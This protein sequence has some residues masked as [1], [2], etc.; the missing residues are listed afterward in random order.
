MM[1]LERSDE[2][3]RLMKGSV[4]PVRGMRRVTPPMMTNACME[5]A[6]TRPTPTNAARS[7]LARA[8]VMNPRIANSRK[9]RM[10]AAAPRSPSS[11]PM[12]EKMKSVETNGMR[13]GM[14]LPI[15]VPTIPPSAKA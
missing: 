2:P 3:P 13:V 4:T 9:S 1:K 8:A 14:P 6:A 5:I 11:S 12:A 15:P 10:T 7:D